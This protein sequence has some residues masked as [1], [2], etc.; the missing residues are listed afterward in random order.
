MSTRSCIMVK[1]RPSDKEKVL[2]FSK[3]LLPVKMRDWKSVDS[4]TG[5]VWRDETDKRDKCQPVTITGNYIGIYC[6]WDGYPEGVGASL[7][8]SF[9]TYEDVL[10]LVVGGSCSS[11]ADDGV[12]RYGNRQ[13]EK[14]SYIKPSQGDTQK[15]VYQC[16]GWAEYVYLFDEERGG[17]L[18]KP[19]CGAN[20]FK[21]GFMLMK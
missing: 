7:K 4:T 12:T 21:K 11:V 10:N 14:W 13:K 3:K 16:C 5:E 8:K 15:S 2:K 20:Q 1:V 9:L 19:L 18:Y 17:W 6:H